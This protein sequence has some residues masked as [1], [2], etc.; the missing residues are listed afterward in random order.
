MIGDAK[1]LLG[2]GKRVDPFCFDGLSSM[3]LLVFAGY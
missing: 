3:F 1:T 2:R